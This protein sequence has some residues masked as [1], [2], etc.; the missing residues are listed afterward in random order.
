MHQS[1][2]SLAD[3]LTVLGALGFG[4]F[5]FLSFNFL[6]F[7]DITTSLLWA[8]AIAVILGGLAFGATLLKRTLGGFKTCIILERIIL[9]LFVVVA[10]IAIRPFAHF[11]A[12]SAQKKA[13]QEKV[14]A[15]IT[16]AEGLF[17]AYEEY[18]NKRILMYQ[19]L[20]NSV[21]GN[22][23]V[24]PTQSKKC[25]PDNVGDPNT[26]IPIKIF[27]MR[28]QLFPNNYEQMK[29]V[30]SIWLLEAKELNKDWS[31]IGIVT[32]LNSVE[33]KVTSWKDDLVTY[34]TYTA[35]CEDDKIDVFP[36]VLDF[37]NV[38]PEFINLKSPTFF[39]ICI[40]I[41]FYVIML[42]SYSFSLRSSKNSYSLF[43]FAQK[44]VRNTDVDVDV[45]Y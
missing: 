27:K 15:N 22:Q 39:S 6:T 3:L 14:T 29:Q 28:A 11:F 33:T 37:P 36:Y 35:P 7:G 41:V 44:K 12:V 5:C 32:V 34:S 21:A 25:F 1:K 2:F 18:A 8:V 30:G 43:S 40:A 45:E 20:L 24:N 31:P 26:Q 16:Q 42:L 9:F 19:N 4:F 38:K 13:I 23:Q 17:V 10:L